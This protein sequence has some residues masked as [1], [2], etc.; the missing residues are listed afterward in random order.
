MQLHTKEL[1]IYDYEIDMEYA[2]VLELEFYSQGLL[3]F[4]A[5]MLQAQTA[6]G[7]ERRPGIVDIRRSAHQSVIHNFGVSC[8]EFAFA[9]RCEHDFRRIVMDVTKTN[10]RLEHELSQG[11]ISSGTIRAFFSR[12]Y[13][14][15]TF[16]VVNWMLPLDGFQSFLEECLGSAAQAELC[17]KS[18][19]VPSSPAHLTDFFLA[20][21]GAA[22]DLIEGRWTNERAV[23][24]AKALGMLQTVGIEK[25]QLEDPDSFTR[26][27]EAFASKEDQQAI[28]EQ[29]KSLRNAKHT[30]NERRNDHLTRAL[31]CALRRDGA[32]SKVQAIETIARTAADAEES[33]KV[34]QLRALRN[35]RELLGHLRLPSA[36][37]TRNDVICAVTAR[38]EALRERSGG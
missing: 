18:F 34:L 30:A 31:A 5:R 23:E 2:C 35:L 32:F 14:L 37:T 26:F 17:L 7:I 38:Q 1:I 21:V 6:W 9:T 16:H 20:I 19:M 8:L 13:D 29:G 36:G 33:R 12:L 11:H 22:E 24:A 27:V 10:L 15:M 3:R 25:K 4:P 28:R